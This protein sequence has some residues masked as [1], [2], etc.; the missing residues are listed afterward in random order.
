MAE[1][2][3]ILLYCGERPPVRKTLDTGT[4][5]CPVCVK[6]QPFKKK[7]L[8]TYCHMYWIPLVPGGHLVD[9]VKY[10]ICKSRFDPGVLDHGPKDVQTALNTAMLRAMIRIMAADGNVEENEVEMICKILPVQMS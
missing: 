6:N 1:C 10:S 7:E 3:L 9:Y 4:F 8:W 2:I 5:F